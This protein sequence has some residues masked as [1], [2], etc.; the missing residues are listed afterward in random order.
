VL[1]TGRWGLTRTRAP[2]SQPSRAPSFLAIRICSLLSSDEVNHPL[3][4]REVSEKLN[5]SKPTLRFWERELEGIIAPLRTNGGQRRYTEEHLLVL[6][7]VLRLKKQGLRLVH[8]RERLANRLN[9]GPRIVGP[10]KMDELAS[11]I[12]EL[13]KAAVYSFLEEKA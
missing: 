8:I 4:I 1:G 3:T 6:E 13:V 7:E 12:A 5:V 10:E 9:G 11:R 2:A